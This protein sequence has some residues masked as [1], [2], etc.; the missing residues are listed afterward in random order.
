MGKNIM[1]EKHSK[2][3]ISKEYM[4]KRKLTHALPTANTMLC[5][6]H[7]MWIFI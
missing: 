2:E 4:K 7:W 6:T 5:L 1:E 3:D